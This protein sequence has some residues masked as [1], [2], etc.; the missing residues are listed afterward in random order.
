[1]SK[2]VYWDAATNLSI[3]NGKIEIPETAVVELAGVKKTFGPPA[4]DAVERDGRAE[5]H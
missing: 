5:A 1:M 4:I 2:G 3:G